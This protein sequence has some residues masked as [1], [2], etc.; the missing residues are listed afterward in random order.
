MAPELDGGCRL[1]LMSVND[2]KSNLPCLLIRMKM[3][4]YATLF[5]FLNT[6]WES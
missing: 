5:L 4:L 1:G 2:E 3:N 6:F